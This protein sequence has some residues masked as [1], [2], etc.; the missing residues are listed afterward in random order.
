V[1]RGQGAKIGTGKQLLALLICLGV[2][3]AAAGVGSLFTGMSVTTWYPTLIK[4]EWAP[5]KWVFGPVWSALYAMMAVAAWLVWRRGGN[6]AQYGLRLFAVQLALNVLWSVLF[7]GLRLPG[8]A[9]A[10]I[11]FLW[12]A[13]GATARVFGRISMSA[14]LLL[15]PY[16]AWVGFAAILN[17]A[18]WRLNA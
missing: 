5:P 11:I 15:V 16:F 4:P 14:S 1:T 10:E 12:L 9:F 2:C 18:I 7:F 13:I 3:F 17:F 8:V 6:E